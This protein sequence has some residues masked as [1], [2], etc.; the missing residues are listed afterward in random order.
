[1]RKLAHLAGISNRSASANA[2][3]CL[4]CSGIQIQD[5]AVMGL[6]VRHR[7]A[8]RLTFKHRCPVPQQ[9][10]LIVLAF[11]DQSRVQRHTLSIPHKISLDVLELTRCPRDRDQEARADCCGGNLSDPTTPGRGESQRFDSMQMALR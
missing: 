7:G 9:P 2:R 5:L 3:E 8:R 6:P 4:R 11:T 10:Q 1:M